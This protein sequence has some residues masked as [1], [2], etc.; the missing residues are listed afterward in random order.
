MNICAIYHKPESN[1]CFALDGKTVRLRLRV[2]KKDVFQNVAVLY[3][4]KY[5]IA[6]EQLR[7]ELS[8]IAC[9]GLFRYYGVTL[10]LSDERLAY[11]FELTADN[12]TQYFCEDGVVDRYDFDL[13]YFNCFQYAYVNSNDVTQNV[14]WLNNAVF[15]QIFVDRFF[16]ASQKDLS[17]VNSKW[18]A[19]PNS[20]SFYGGDLDGVR[21]KLDYVESLGV[22]A[23]YLTPVFR[24]K[25]NHKYDVIDYYQV[26]LAFGG[27]DALKR[28]SDECHRRGMRLVLD[29]VFNHVSEDF[30]PFRDV[31]ARGR[32]SKYFDW[33]VIDGNRAD[34]KK[35]NY[36]CFA[37]C[38]Y[39]PK[40]NT[41]NPEVQTYLCDV[42][43]FWMKNYG[44]DGW[45][46]DVSDE[47][48]HG[49]WRVFR[50]A[51]KSINPDACLIGENWHN[52]E[53]YLGGEQFDGIMNYAFT[54]QMMDFFGGKA[55]S[56][57]V[58][59][60]L[61]G[62]LMRYSDV[63]NGMMF[64]L[65][66]CHDTHRFYSL[67]KCNKDA[68]LCAVALGVFMSGS[69]CLYYGDE[70]ATEGGYDP[71]NRRA[72]DW[73]KLTE[74]DTQNFKDNVVALLKLKRQPALKGEVSVFCEKGLL[75]VR[76][77]SS[78]QT[79]TLYVNRDGVAT[80]KSGITF[81]KTNGKYSF[82]VQGGLL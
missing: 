9:D 47:V 39:M 57:Q 75:A 3:N 60:K 6:T 18:N 30:A 53:S 41:A 78:K 24:S 80:D 46:L 44:V 58:S 10:H 13:A 71:D 22:N 23:L 4:T 15:Y 31:V 27:N 62:L 8:E 67:V 73:D 50:T 63:T 2:D 43:A 74:P 42:A 48:S 25:S 82:F 56:A 45:R 77:S 21:E 35:H 68:F 20:K 64:N 40:L 55:D 70:I 38:D 12:K 66:D 32:A 5:D 11:V 76:R 72:F 59:D 7:A 17:Y 52:S 37:Q 19:L 69:F 79:L 81:G 26:D 61:N 65:L 34:K 51:V 54:K 16:S 29:A 1:Y 36:R 49:F 28:L 14:A 33:F